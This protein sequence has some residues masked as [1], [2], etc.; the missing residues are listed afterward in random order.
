M[1][2]GPRLRNGVS[3]LDLFFDFRRSKFLKNTYNRELDGHSY[4]LL[5]ARDDE[6]IYCG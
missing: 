3:R 2:T 1:M 4:S 5:R 6:M